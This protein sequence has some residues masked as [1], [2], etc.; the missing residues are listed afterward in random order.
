MPMTHN[1]RYALAALRLLRFPAPENPHT[2]SIIKPI[3][4]I[5]NTKNVISQSVVDITD[6]SCTGGGG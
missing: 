6:V 2:N 3:H 4:G 5:M 1:M